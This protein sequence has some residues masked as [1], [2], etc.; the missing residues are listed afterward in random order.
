MKK[1]CTSV[2]IP[3]EDGIITQNGLPHSLHLLTD[4]YVN[5]DDWFCIDKEVHQAATAGLQYLGANQLAFY[6]KN[7]GLQVVPRNKCK[8]ITASTIGFHVM[9][10]IPDEFV[11]VC[12]NNEEVVVEFEVGVVYDGEKHYDIVNVQLFNSKQL[13]KHFVELTSPDD[14]GECV[15]PTMHEMWVTEFEVKERKL[16][17]TLCNPGMLIGKSGKTLDALEEALGCKIQ[18]IPK[19]KSSWYEK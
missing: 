16:V 11:D 10:W 12:L 9:T 8:K 15:F 19:S 17:V 6:C 2:L 7:K 13:I 18:I 5:I 1:I 14:L 4:E 3:D